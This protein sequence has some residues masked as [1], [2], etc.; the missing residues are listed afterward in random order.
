MNPPGPQRLAGRDPMDIAS[1]ETDKYYDSL[2]YE[3]MP[4]SEALAIEQDRNRAHRELAKSAIE[5]A[6]GFDFKR[7]G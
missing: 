6:M 1:E 5:Q 2:F 7:M 3:G 4:E